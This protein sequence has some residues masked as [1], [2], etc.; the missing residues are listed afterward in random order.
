MLIS[1]FMDVFRKGK[2]LSDAETWKNRTVA[3][4]SLVALLAALLGIAKAF[5]LPLEV[6][7]QTIENLAAG[8]VAAVGVVN[9]VMHV[10]TSARIGLPPVGDAGAASGGRGEG[11]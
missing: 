1:D 2:E 8:V 6:D 7:Q 10:I 3:A 5:G 9:A 4:N 11:S